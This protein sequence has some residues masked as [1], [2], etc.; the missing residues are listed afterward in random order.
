VSVP[1]RSTD[2][3]TCVVFTEAIT[4]TKGAPTSE[5]AFSEWLRTNTEGFNRDRAAW[6][7]V[8]N[9]RQYTDGIG[10]RVTVTHVDSPGSGYVVSDR[11]TCTQS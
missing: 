10:H 8:S 9:R 2:R 3:E 4:D 1:V 5:R 11:S 6:R 7:L